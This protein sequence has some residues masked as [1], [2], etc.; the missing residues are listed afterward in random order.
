MKSK[1]QLGMYTVLIED[2]DSIQIQAPTLIRPISLDSKQV[3]ELHMWLN[4]VHPQGVPTGTNP[5]SAS[6][7]TQ[8]HITPAPESQGTTE[9]AAPAASTAN[10]EQIT[11]QAIRAAIITAQSEYPAALAPENRDRFIEQLTRNPQIKPLVTQGKIS[12]KQIM[13]WT[14]QSISNP[15]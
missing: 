8:E 4:E 11:Q 10:P 9:P 13:L 1:K 2:D 6:P 15:A 3:G 12:Y 5:T 14:E 7:I